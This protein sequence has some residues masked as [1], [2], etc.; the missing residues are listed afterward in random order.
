MQGDN[1]PCQH[2]P[3]A[4]LVPDA[5]SPDQDYQA[6]PGIPQLDGYTPSNDEWA[7]KCCM[8]ETFYKTEDEPIHSL[9]TDSVIFATMDTCGRDLLSC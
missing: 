9:N 5:F 1:L 2:L 4:V 8:Y 7:C 6:S 3:A